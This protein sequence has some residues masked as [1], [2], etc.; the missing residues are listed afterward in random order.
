ME[1]QG[2]FVDVVHVL[3]G[4]H[5][6]GLD[7]A[8]Q[9]DLGLDVRGQ[10]LFGAAQQDIGLD[11]DGAQF[12]DAVL[13]G[14]GLDLPGALDVG[15]QGEVDVADVLFA[16]VPLELPDGL[17]ERQAL[18]VAHG[19]ADLDDGHIRRGGHR[20]DG[21]LDFVGDVGDD[22]DGAAQ[23]V[24]PALLGDDVVIDAAGGEVVLLAQGDRGVAFVVAQVQVGFGPVFGDEDLAVLERVHGAGVHV[25]VG[26]QL[27]KGDAEPPGFQ[28]GA[29]GRGGHALPQGGQHPAGDEDD[30]GFHKSFKIPSQTQCQGEVRGE[31]AGNQAGASGRGLCSGSAG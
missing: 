5:R 15:H 21:L 22:L 17:Q 28:Q 18:D 13:G 16:Q 26:I 10:D 6:L 2:N 31:A 24:P 29:D 23:I 14:F 9:G 30:F 8:E 1:Q 25:D 7:V 3:G 19:A 20:H 27:L 11:A 12:L 4:D